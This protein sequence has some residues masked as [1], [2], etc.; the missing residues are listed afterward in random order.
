M[1]KGYLFNEKRQGFMDVTDVCI[2][3]DNVMIT[4]SGQKVHVHL[5]KPGRPVSFR[6]EEVSA[7]HPLKVLVATRKLAGGF[8]DFRIIDIA[9]VSDQDVP[10]ETGAWR[11]DYP[12]LENGKGAFVTEA[13]AYAGRTWEEM[14]ADLFMSPTQL[15]ACLAK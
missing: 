5:D 4:R 1:Q 10:A 15:A 6:M 12:I 2:S 9:E 7:P 14:A 8:K 11:L 3:S 13:Q